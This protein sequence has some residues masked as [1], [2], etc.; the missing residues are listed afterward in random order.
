[1]VRREPNPRAADYSRFGFGRVVVVPDLAAWIRHPVSKI[2]AVG[3][4]GRPAALLAAAE[5][6]FAGR[7]APTVSHP[8]FLEFLRPGISKAW[9]VRWLA[10]RLGVDRSATMA[11]GDQL[12][13]LGMIAEAGIGVAMPSAP[14]AVRAA[15]RVIAPPVDEEGAAAVIEELVLGAARRPGRQIDRP[16]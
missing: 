12:N 4:A 9:A 2:I 6:D 5:A 14:A 3:E 15:A 1:M 16:A 11:I 13:D 8:M 7:A 10:R